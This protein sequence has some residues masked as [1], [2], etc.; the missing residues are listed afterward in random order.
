MTLLLH[1]DIGHDPDDAIALAY[2]LESGYNP[3]Y[4]TIAPGFKGQCDIVY[5]ILREYDRKPYPIIMRSEDKIGNYEPGKHS[6][7]MANGLFYDLL[8]GT[9][10]VKDAIII[11]PAKNL[12]GRIKANRMFFQGGY[13]PNSVAPLD[14]FKGETHVQS[15]NPSGARSDFKQLL[16]DDAIVAKYY[17]GKNVCHGFTKADVEKIWKPKSKKMANFFDEHKPTKA[18]HDVLA[19]MI[20][21]GQIKPIWE[22]ASPEFSGLKMT[23]VSTTKE[24]YSLIGIECEAG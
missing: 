2:L 12:G 7:L 10:P 1:T 9:I 4:I 22:Q 18:T 16:S 3:D 23:T 6:A 15:F 19:C 11:G 5:G 14:K 13:S 17:I 21:T 24:I 20:F 8:M